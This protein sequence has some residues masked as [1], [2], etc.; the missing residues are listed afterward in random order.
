LKDGLRVWLERKAGEIGRRRKSCGVGVGV[1]IWRFT[2]RICLG[3][4]DEIHNDKSIKGKEE[5]DCDRGEGKV[6]GLRRFWE[7]MSGSEKNLG[8]QEDIN[9]EDI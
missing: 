3:E 1:L 4:K 2:R 7:Q 8:N 5:T 9:Q 6:E